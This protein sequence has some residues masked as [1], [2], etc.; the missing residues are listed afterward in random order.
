VASLIADE[1]FDIPDNL[2]VDGAG[3]AVLE[4]QVH[5]WDGVLGEDGSVRDITCKN[6]IPS[7]NVHP[8]VS[9][10]P[11]RSFLQFRDI[12]SRFDVRMAADST[13][14]R[15][16]NLLMALSFGVH[17]EQ[18][19]HL[20]GLTWPRPFLLRPLLTYVSAWS[21]GVDFRNVVLGSSLL[22]HVG[23]FAVRLVLKR[24]V[25]MSAYRQSLRNGIPSGSF[26][27]C[28][29]RAWR[30]GRLGNSTSRVKLAAESVLTRTPRIL[31][32]AAAELASIKVPGSLVC[33]YLS[34]N[35]FTGDK[36]LIVIFKVHIKLQPPSASERQFPLSQILL[37]LPQATTVVPRRGDHNHSRMSFKIAPLLYL[38][39]SSNKLRVRRM[40]CRQ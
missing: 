23:R 29:L 17:R 1:S 24:V 28:A 27:L 10:S 21:Y 26:R 2:S 37:C 7:A 12:H 35:S 30:R 14:L 20:T 9:L 18:L 36:G 25:G 34:A 38:V 39:Q 15:M 16:V 3:N 13:M 40:P 31:V 6:N 4:L 32:V 11:S 19:E 8:V 22:D 5:L 33:V